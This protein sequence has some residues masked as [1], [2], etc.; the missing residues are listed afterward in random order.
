MCLAPREAWRGAREQPARLPPFFERP[1]PARDSSKPSNAV[2]SRTTPVT[3]P[4][5]GTALRCSASVRTPASVHAEVARVLAWQPAG[6]HAPSNWKQAY[7][8]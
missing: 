4:L 2:G 1:F 5:I 7:R 8:L 6:P 3:P